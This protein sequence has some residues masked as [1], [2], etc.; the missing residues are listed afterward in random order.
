MIRLTVIYNLQ[1][2]VNEEEFT[3]WRL[4]EHQRNNLDIEGVIR[5]DFSRIGA[6][7]PRDTQPAYRYITTLDWQDWQSF[8]KGFYAP[9]VQASMKQNLQKLNNPVF[10]ISEILV[11]EI[12]HE[13]NISTTS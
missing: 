7:W 13:T 2:D 11:N 5:T 12:K 10:L 4:T 6:T 9:K 8:Q 1:A 3:K